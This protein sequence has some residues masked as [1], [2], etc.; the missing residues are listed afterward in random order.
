MKKIL[1]ISVSMEEQQMIEATMKAS[2]KEAF[3]IETTASFAQPAEWWSKNK[4]DILVIRLP[5]DQALQE[6]FFQRI[7]KE[8]PKDLPL[9]FICETVSSSLM[10]LT[11]Q[12]AKVRILKTPL[13]SQILWRG[14]QELQLEFAGHQKAAHRYMTDQEVTISSDFREGKVVGRLKNLS[15]SGVY[16]EVDENILALKNDEIVRLHVLIT[17]LREYMF[18]CKIV[19]VKDLGE[20]RLGFGGTFMDKNEVLNSLLK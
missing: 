5:E 12:L 9:L 17:N 4:I 13:E 18:D 6:Y 8:L 7:R 10:Q 1:I 15:V 2:G 11:N 14:L 20:G 16:F 19:W 3:S